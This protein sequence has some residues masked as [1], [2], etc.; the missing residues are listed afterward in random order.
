MAI[1]IQR[2]EPEFGVNERE[3]HG[4]WDDTRVSAFL[5]IYTHT[6]VPYLRNLLI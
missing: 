3:G 1:S 6:D 2:R 5:P 4:E